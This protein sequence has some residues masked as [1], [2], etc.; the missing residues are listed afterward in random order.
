M[1]LSLAQRKA[2]TKQMARRNTLSEL[3]STRI[4]VYSPLDSEW[5]RRNQ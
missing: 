1:R 2:V 4:S 5:V 3:W